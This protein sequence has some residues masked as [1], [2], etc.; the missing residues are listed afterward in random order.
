MICVID[1]EHRPPARTTHNSIFTGKRSGCVII[2][3]DSSWNTYLRF[4][5]PEFLFLEGRMIER[6]NTQLYWMI[7]FLPSK[8][9]S[10]WKSKI[11]LQ[12]RRIN[13]IYERNYT[14]RFHF[15]CHWRQRILL[16]TLKIILAHLQFFIIFLFFYLYD[17]L[18][19]RKKKK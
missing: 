19:E 13:F 17:S 4:Q 12:F 14:T 6:V 16:T 3:E 8:F 5:N 2:L 1:G 9:Q 10:F 11:F 15:H 7:N 18:T